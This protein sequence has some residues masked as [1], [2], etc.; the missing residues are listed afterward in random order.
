MRGQIKDGKG[1]GKER[2]ARRLIFKCPEF[3][4]FFELK[5]GPVLAASTPHERRLC[6]HPI[7][8][9]W[10]FDG[11]HQQHVLHPFQPLQINA[12]TRANLLRAQKPVCIRQAG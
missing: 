4:I 9:V 12:F 10:M 2:G 11:Q 6:R 1:V 7:N 3:T 8:D 5:G